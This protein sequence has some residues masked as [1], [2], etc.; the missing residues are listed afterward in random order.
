M[1]IITSPSTF[2]TLSNRIRTLRQLYQ[3]HSI[4]ITSGLVS[5]HPH[6]T[7]PKLLYSFNL[8]LAGPRPPPPPPSPTLTAYASLL[9]SSIEEPSTFCYN[10]AIRA[11]TLLSSPAHAL[12]LFNEMLRRGSAAPDFHSFPFAFKACGLLTDV[13]SACSL[14]GL[15]L[16]LGFS[17]DI[18]IVNSLIH[19]YSISGHVD[20][21][22]CIFKECPFKD[23]VSYNTMIDGLVKSGDVSSARRLF[24]EMRERD[25][26]TWGTLIAGYAQLNMCRE[27]IELFSQLMES[28][29]RPDN[30]ALVSALSACAQLGEM[31]T[32]RNIHEYIVKNHLLVDPFLCTGLVDLYAKC[33]SLQTAIEVFQANPRKNLH[34]WNAMI[35]GLAVHGRGLRSV[36]YFLKMVDCG[37]KPDGITLLGVL[38]GCSHSG[39]V[40]EACRIFDEMETV[41]GV[42][43]EPKHY[44]CLMDLL[45]RAGLVNE[46]IDLIREVPENEDIFIWGSILGGCRKNGNVKVAEE[47]AKKV[48]ELF[49]EDGGVYSI[50]AGVYAGADRWEDVVR[51]RASMS[52]G[53]ARRMAGCSVIKVDGIVNEFVSSDSLH[54]GSGDI[55]SVLD[56]IDKHQIELY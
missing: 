23:V 42:T 18:F 26:V 47:T 45:G 17:T 2:F 36:D 6:L 9:F 28:Q 33:G 51:T 39:L 13:S 15:A 10:I 48:M 32:G 40:N 34:T 8:L 43:R 41:Y 46:A 27:A 38:V 44:G 53:P 3:L 19:V 54:A 30:V 16:R 52:A 31:D 5:S 14:H 29:L 7:L 56:A 37:I 12:H 21:A 11:H 25:S 55:Y 20:G 35:V 4:A 1:R 49:P 24:E 50:M 22:F